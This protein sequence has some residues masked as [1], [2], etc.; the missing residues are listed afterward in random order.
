MIIMR[1]NR[2]EIISDIL[3][4]I[5]SKINRISSI[6][7]YVNLSASLAKKYLALMKE[8]G[9]IEE[10]DGEYVITEKERKVLEQIRSIRKAEIDLI[11]LVNEL[12]K[13]INLTE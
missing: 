5:D 11:T 8:N 6:M 2:E 4:A 9:L 13:E 1:R 7:K 10:K 12:K 3:E